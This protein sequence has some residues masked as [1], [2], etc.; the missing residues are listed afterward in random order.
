MISVV[1]MVNIHHIMENGQ[2]PRP[3]IMKSRTALA[4][5]ILIVA[6]SLCLAHSKMEARRGSG[7]CARRRITVNCNILSTSF[8]GMRRDPGLR[9]IFT[10]GK[11][12]STEE[13]RTS[14]W[15]LA[16]NQAPAFLASSGMFR[17]NWGFVICTASLIGRLSIT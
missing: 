13:V 14:T 6:L 4:V 9:L 7:G 3:Q 16:G 5:G 17:L 10:L 11:F 8:D 1:G 12:H 15:R 2:A